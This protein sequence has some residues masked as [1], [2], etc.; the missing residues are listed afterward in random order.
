M[1]AGTRISARVPKEVEQLHWR[2]REVATLVYALHAATAAEVCEALPGELHNASVRSF[3]NRLVKKGIL[4]RIM[5]DRTY[6]YLPA[7]SAGDSRTMA[8]KRFA[9]DHFAGSIEEAASTMEALLKPGC[10]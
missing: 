3:L 6:V 10:D 8:L 9:E 7:V 4:R 2:E 1:S 5:S